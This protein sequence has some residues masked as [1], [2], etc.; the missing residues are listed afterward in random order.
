MTRSYRRSGEV[1]PVGVR[2]LVDPRPDGDR[3]FG[4]VIS[5]FCA[6]GSCSSQGR[7]AL[8]RG[9]NPFRT[10]RPLTRSP[11]AVGA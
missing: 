5:A 10:D 6:P 1:V 9:T 4:T 2:E 11:R 3:L 8:G 7:R